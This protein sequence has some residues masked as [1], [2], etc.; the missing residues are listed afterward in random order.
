MLVRLWHMVPESLRLKLKSK[1]AD[2]GL[3]WTRLPVGDAD[4]QDYFETS[5][6]SGSEDYRFLCDNQYDEIQ[7]VQLSGRLYEEEELAL[8]QAHVTPGSVIVDAGANVGNHAVAFAKRFQAKKVIAFEPGARQFRLLQ[9]N[10]A[11]NNLENVIELHKT[12]LSNAQS[13]AHLN[14]WDNNLGS[15]RIGDTGEEIDLVRGD[16]VLDGRIDFIKM[17]VEGHEGEALAGLTETIA[18]TR[19]KLFIEVEEDDVVDQWL[20]D[21]NY[22]II[23]TFAR[24][25]D[26][27]N[28]LAVP[29]ESVSD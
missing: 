20:R 19:P 27:Q 16:D 13:T 6:T 14:N 10:V 18:R 29:K 7:K 4:V 25:E 3:R 28:V 21:N 23:D 1:V 15:A 22:V 24:Y 5:F 8:M 11:L 2:T 26:R 12:G 17:D 9:F